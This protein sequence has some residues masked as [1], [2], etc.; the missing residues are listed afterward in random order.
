MNR[1]HLKTV[2]DFLCNFCNIVSKTSHE[3][4]LHYFAHCDIVEALD[5]DLELLSCTMCGTQC[6]DDDEL[7]QHLLIHEDEADSHAT[8]CILCSK[9]ISSYSQIHEHTKNHHLD[10]LSH[11]CLEC[12]RCFVYGVKFLIHVRNHKEKKP[13]IHLCT[14]CGRNFPSAPL[15][16]KHTKIEHEKIYKCPYCDDVVYKSVTAFRQHVDGHT[17][18]RK[19]QCPL[20]PK[21]YSIR[22]KFKSH[23]AFHLNDKM[24]ACP[25]CG[26][27]FEKSSSLKVHMQRHD[28]TLVKRHS[29]G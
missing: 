4:S 24:N 13:L 23:Y 9:V 25:I 7:M 16:K 19:Y 5:P 22:N 17:N 26:K 12:N 6:S 15:L 11:R 18:S 10:K 8:A 2:S 3:N 14:E 20:C 29:C 27:G 21:S 1:V 28:G